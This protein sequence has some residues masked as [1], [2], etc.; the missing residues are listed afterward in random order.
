MNLSPDNQDYF[1]QVLRQRAGQL[2]ARR[3]AEL[4]STAR[5][6]LVF[7]LC[8]ERFWLPLQGL[9]EVLP[10]QHCTPVPGA[11]ANLLGVVNIRGEIR[12]VLDLMQL[13][14]MPLSGERPP[15][16]VVLVRHGNAEIGLRVDEVDRIET[17]AEQTILSNKEKHDGQ[18]SSEKQRTSSRAVVLNL[19][20]LF[21][22]IPNLQ[23]GR[24]LQ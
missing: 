20:E 2:A 16:Y 21:L 12:S 24:K 15:G 23:S 3:T 5:P 10:F 13:L 14:N 11:P 19:E 9:V 8:G 6:G 7:T 22:H 17:V 1:S 4:Q 18:A